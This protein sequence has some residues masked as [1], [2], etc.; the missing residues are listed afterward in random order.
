MKRLLATFKLDVLNQYRQGIYIV[1]VAMLVILGG[2]AY[3]L[4]K[5]A[6]TIMP[7]ILLTNMAIATFVFLGGYVLMEKGE[8]TLE[9]MMISPL[10]S[11]EYLL[12]KITTLTGLGGTREYGFVCHCSFDGTIDAP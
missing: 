7:M 4:P 5:E 2:L 11:N 12:S 9:G 3:V 1:S 8:G 10:R 6:G